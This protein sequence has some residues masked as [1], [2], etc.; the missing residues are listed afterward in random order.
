MELL[1]LPHVRELRS[2]R[3]IM[4]AGALP[5]SL[6]EQRQRAVLV[7][8]DQRHACRDRRAKRN[9]AWR[10][11]PGCCISSAPFV[12]APVARVGSR[13]RGEAVRIVARRLLGARQRRFRFGIARQAAIRVGQ[14]E[15]R[16]TRSSGSAPRRVSACSRAGAV[17]ALRHEA[18]RQIHAGHLRDTAPVAPPRRSSGSTL[19][20]PALVAQEH[21]VPEV[22]GRQRR[23]QLQGA[24]VLAFRRPS[25]SSRTLR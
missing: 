11:L 12:A 25:S 9:A 13:Q 3:K 18:R 19:I 17:I 1:F 6:F 21:A 7:A 2:R 5:V 24:A 4:P 8:Q 23:V 16:S 22:R 15:L 20:Q 14:Q 10:V